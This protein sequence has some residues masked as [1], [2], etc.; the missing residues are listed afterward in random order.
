[1]DPSKEKSLTKN[2]PDE[3]ENENEIV[4]ESTDTDEEFEEQ[5]E[6][7]DCCGNPIEPRR[8]RNTCDCDDNWFSE[9][10]LLTLHNLCGVYF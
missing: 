4:E 5:D 9:L 3:D 6:F 8:K 1:M 10:I 7:S 2:L